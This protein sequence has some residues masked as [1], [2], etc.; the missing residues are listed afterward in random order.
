MRLAALI[1]ALSL[2]A[3]AEPK[4]DPPKAEPAPKQA[5]PADAQPTAST[6]L[7]IDAAGQAL[8]IA[9][10]AAGLA[11]RASDRPTLVPMFVPGGAGLGGRF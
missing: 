7:Y 4:T 3:R 8:G 10:L 1:L 9:L 11:T 6:L 5:V 2:A